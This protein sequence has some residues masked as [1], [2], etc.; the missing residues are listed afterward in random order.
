[1]SYGK[2]ERE[3]RVGYPRPSSKIVFV[4]YLK[5]K[6]DRAPCIFIA[7]PRNL[8]HSSNLEDTCPPA[9]G[10]SHGLGQMPQEEVCGVMR[11]GRW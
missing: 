9:P 4:V 6:V 1:M 8:T 2:D 10:G 7:K 3:Y 11:R 5:F